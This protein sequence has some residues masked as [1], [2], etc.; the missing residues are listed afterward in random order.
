MRMPP[1]QACLG[2]RCPLRGLLKDIPELCRGDL[3]NREDARLPLKEPGKVFRDR[4]AE[5][6]ADPGGLKRVHLV[7]FQF[8]DPRPRM[9][10]VVFPGEQ[11]RILPHG[12]FPSVRML[13]GLCD[14]FAEELFPSLDFHDPLSRGSGI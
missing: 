13:V 1:L 11:P 6:R 4:R 3:D 5:L 7:F 8:V 9:E 14:E 2:Q 10:N 12:G